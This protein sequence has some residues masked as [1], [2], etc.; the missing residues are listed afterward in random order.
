MYGLPEFELVTDHE[1]LKVIYSTRSKST[2]RIERWVLRLQPYNYRVCYVPSRKNIAD[3]LSRLTK[4]EDSFH[5]QDDDE[6]VRMV[7]SHTT[8]VA[9]RIKEVKQASAQDSELQAIRKCLIDGKWDSVPKQYL[10][11]RR[12]LTFIGHVI[13]RGTR[14][15]MP[16]SLRKRVVNLA[17]EG[18]Q[19]VVKTKDRLRTKVWLPGM[20]REAERR[21]AECYGCQLVT[22]NV[23]PPPL[24]PTSMPPQP[25]EELALDL[26]GPLPAGDSLLVL[27]DYYSRWIEVDVI[28]AT[29]SKV[30]VQRLD[31]QFARHG[32]PNALRT[33]NGSNLVS[34]EMEDYLNELGIEHRYTTPLWPRVMAKWRGRIGHF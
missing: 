31:A 11:V 7:A 34:K 23:P 28:R 10:P 5:S 3:A 16:R 15:V 2:A 8:P 24:K 21:C 25:W 4:I 9:L 1:A 12:E 33:D 20:D 30:I 22:K 29:T 26:L 19:G 13:L 14:I 18:H 27:V 6:Y 17:H 32:I